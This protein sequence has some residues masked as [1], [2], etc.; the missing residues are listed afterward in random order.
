MILFMIGSGVAGA[1]T[2]V[3]VLIAMRVVQAA[4]ASAVLAIGKILSF[5]ALKHY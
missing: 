5:M 2:H 1:A 3:G 4:G